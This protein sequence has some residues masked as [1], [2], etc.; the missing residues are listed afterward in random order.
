[1]QILS[2][3]LISPVFE[4]LLIVVMIGGVLGLT[5]IA[6]LYSPFLFTADKLATY[7]RWVAS[8]TSKLPF[9]YISTNKVFV[10]IFLGMCFAM[11]C[12]V[13]LSKNYKRTVPLAILVMIFVLVAGSI[14]DYIVSYNTP[15]INVYDTG[16]GIT[17]SV[18]CKNKS[19]P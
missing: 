17:L 1:M 19:H 9:S 8:T 5:G 16:D 15:R 4:L 10:Y 2:N 14:S 12:L 13:V 11:I 7:I 18:H 6:V 3:L